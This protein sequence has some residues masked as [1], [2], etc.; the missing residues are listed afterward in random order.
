LLA[1]GKQ[2]LQRLLAAGQVRV[3]GDHSG[4]GDEE[5]AAGFRQALQVHHTRLGARDQFFQRESWPEID[6]RARRKAR[7]DVA[8]ERLRHQIEFHMKVIALQQPVFAVTPAVAAHPVHRAFGHLDF[9]RRI[10]RQ[11]N[12]RR[13]GML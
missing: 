1:T 13:H 11:A 8:R 5:T 3:R 2:R 6:G 4:V 9:F 10:A 12:A 7:R